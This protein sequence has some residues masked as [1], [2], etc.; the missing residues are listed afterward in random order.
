MASF[1]EIVDSADALS[2]EEQQTLIEILKGRLRERR[3][4]ELLGDVRDA[5][6]EFAQGKIK[7]ASVEGIMKQIRG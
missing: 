3:R 6:E 4:E 5:E 1:A 2:A 7:A